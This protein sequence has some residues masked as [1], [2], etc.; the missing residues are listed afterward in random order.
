MYS[1]SPSFA[2]PNPFVLDRIKANGASLA[3]SSRNACAFAAFWIRRVPDR[4]SIKRARSDLDA[5][6]ALAL[7][8][9]ETRTARGR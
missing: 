6:A 7:A 1:P 9:E 4:W 8:V 2:R 5:D 3:I